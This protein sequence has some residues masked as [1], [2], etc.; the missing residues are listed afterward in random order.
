M[1]ELGSCEETSV[2]RWQFLCCSFVFQFV[3]N[4]I[5]TV[6]CFFFFFKQIVL[7]QYFVVFES[8]DI[9]T[10]RTVLLLA[11]SAVF[12]ASSLCSQS[13][14]QLFCLQS[15]GPMNRAHFW[16]QVGGRLTVEIW[17]SQI[18]RVRF[19]NPGASQAECCATS[20]VV[21]DLPF[22]HHVPSDTFF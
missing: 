6:I 20:I 16:H 4:S 13:H 10:Y 18:L 7:V 12:P 11:G 1:P 5:Y 3:S 2:G 14:A 8:Q 15:V 22:N 19:R 9:P 17:T 21:M